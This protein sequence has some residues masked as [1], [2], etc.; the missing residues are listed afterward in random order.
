MPP[1]VPRSREEVRMEPHPPDDRER[2]IREALGLER[3]PLPQV[4]RGWLRSY[5]AYL[6]VRLAMPFDAWY[7]G[8]LARI[9]QT[10]LQVSVTGLLDPD[11]QLGY[12]FDGLVCLARLGDQTRRL[13]LVDVEVDPD[14]PNFQLLD[15]YWYWFWN[16][17]F[18]PAI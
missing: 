17:R 6:T 12:E 2:R 14:H 16:W 15:D 4:Q 8:D 5:R 18:D 1:P 11:E 7:T 9:G 3:G 13:P 10:I